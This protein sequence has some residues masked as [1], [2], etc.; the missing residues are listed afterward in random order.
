MSH[1]SL[2]D[3][4]FRLCFFLAFCMSC[5]FLLN[6]G[7][8]ILGNRDWGKE[9]FS[10]KFYVNLT[11]TGLCSCRLQNFQ[12]P[13]F[14]CHG[15]SCYPWAS[16]S[17][18]PQTESTSCSPSSWNSLLVR[19][20]CVWETLYNLMTESHSFSGPMFLVCDLHQ[21]FLAFFSFPRWDRLAVGSGINCIHS[22]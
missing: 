21:C 18:P 17:S 10:V 13:L 22:P 20:L 2:S 12:I 5:N 6:S 7:H 15:L 1:L 4:C 19:W 14:P 3:A 8:D 16:L 11:R 9:A